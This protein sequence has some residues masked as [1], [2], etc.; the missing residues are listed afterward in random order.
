ML[1]Y[2]PATR[3]RVFD[4]RKQNLPASLNSKGFLAQPWLL[5]KFLKEIANQASQRNKYNRKLS[6]ENT[7]CV[8]ITL[9]SPLE[10]RDQTLEHSIMPALEESGASSTLVPRR[11]IQLPLA[12]LNSSIYIYSCLLS[13]R[14]EANKILAAR[15]S[16][17]C[18]LQNFQFLM[19]WRFTLGD[20]CS[21]VR[22]YDAHESIY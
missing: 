16:E 9:F 3:V 13:R 1:C 8:P 4:Y 22:L 2:S 10:A 6:R 15:E 14:V 17:Q 12:V 7:S 20:Q 19:C 18:P 11:A 5:Y 21:V